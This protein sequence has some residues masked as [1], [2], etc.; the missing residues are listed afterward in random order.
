MSLVP[1]LSCSPSADEARAVP[2]NG[3]FS[4]GEAAQQVKSQEVQVSP[5]VQKCH[6]S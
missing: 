5:S 1:G 6:P 3:S 2:V 4:E